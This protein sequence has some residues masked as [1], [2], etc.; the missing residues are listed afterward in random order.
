M[1][2]VSIPFS[3][4]VGCES[5]PFFINCKLMLCWVSILVDMLLR[6][7][8]NATQRSTLLSFFLP[9]DCVN[10]FRSHTLAQWPEK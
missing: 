9:T 2:I 5:G 7:V 1:G 10:I 8:R 4:R 3:Q 6:K